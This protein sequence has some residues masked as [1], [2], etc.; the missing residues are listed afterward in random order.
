MPACARRRPARGAHRRRPGRLLRRLRRRALP[1]PRLRR[2]PRPAG[3]RPERIGRWDRGVDLAALRSGARDAGMHRGEVN[4]LYAGRLTSEKGVELLARGVPRRPR[5]RRAPAPG[6]SRRRPR[7]GGAAR[8]AGRA[9]D[10]P[11]MARRTR[12]RPGLRERRRVPVRQPD[13][14][15][16]AGDPRGPGERP[17]GGRG[18][19]RGSGVADRLRRDRPAHQPDPDALAAALL[20]VTSTPLLAQRL[21]QAG[22]AA[23]RERTWPAS[24]AQLAAGYRSVTARTRRRGQTR[25]A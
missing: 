20:A 11:G 6:A 1:Q 19:C 3:R 7:G 4:V 12:A 14:H 9:R 23:V 8:A 2:A 25:V 21:R 17:A 16:R 10:V 13:R 18:R 5:A 22:L 24:L 15:V